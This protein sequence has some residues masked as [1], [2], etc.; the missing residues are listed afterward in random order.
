MTDL[1]YGTFAQDE[2]MPL[3]PS[4]F[5]RGNF[6]TLTFFPEVF[7]FDTADV[8]FDRVLDDMRM[9]PFVAPLAPG[10]ILQPRGFQKETIIPAS[11]KPKDQITGKEVLSRMAGE[12]I[13]GEMSAADREAAIREMYLMKH[14]ERIA[15]RHEWMAS[16]ILRT[17]SVTIAGDDYPST[18]VNFARAAALTV[19]LLTTARWGET[20]VSPFDDVD[21]WMN[22]TASECGA[23]VDIVVM[24]KLAWGFF[25]DDPKT[26]KALDTTLGQT[27]AIDLGFTPG[28][29]GAPQFKGR[30]GAVEFY[31]YNDVYHDDSF[32]KQQL[33]PDYTVMMGSRSGYAGSKLCGVVQHAENHYEK[34]EFFP[35]EWIDQNTGA[36]WVE[37]ITSPILAPKRVNASFC[38]TVR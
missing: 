6:L 21:G 24:D 27:A 17:G 2:L 11:I 19:T 7:E 8:Y 29:P 31:V 36:Q 15:R 9:A 12:R 5:V 28:V 37:T 4:L 10:K 18:V 38:A 16:S 14:Q 35:H 1:N 13:G 25:A 3:I 26:Q 23:A 30:I 22:D 20:G 33:V 32:T 34:G